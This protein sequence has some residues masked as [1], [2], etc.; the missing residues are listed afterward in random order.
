MPGVIPQYATPYA[1]VTLGSIGPDI[2]S[3]SIVGVGVQGEMPQQQ[4]T[5]WTPWSFRVA[6]PK[7]LRRL[8]NL[9]PASPTM[10]PGYYYTPPA[11]FQ[12]IGIPEPSSFLAAQLPTRPAS[13]RTG[14]PPVRHFAINP[15]PSM[16]PPLPTYPT[17]ASFRGQ[18]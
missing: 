8:R 3:H 9:G 13:G 14:T 18:F 5:E 12:I 10:S 15:F 17:P 4:P 2:P 7:P 11:L 16:R 1:R 6:A